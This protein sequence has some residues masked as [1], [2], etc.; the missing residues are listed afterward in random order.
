MATA[1]EVGSDFNTHLFTTNAV[2]SLHDRNAIQSTILSI[3]K[4]ISQAKLDISQLRKGLEDRIADHADLI[5]HRASLASVISLLRQ[6]PLEI[7]GQIFAY[8]TLDDPRFPVSASHVCQLW[9]RASL[10]S[11]DIW[12]TICIG[13][14]CRKEYMELFIQ[15]SKSRPVSLKYSGNLPIQSL[16]DISTVLSDVG[17]NCRWKEIHVHPR[18]NSLPNIL[19]KSWDTLES[20]ILTTS[21]DS[22]VRVLDLTSATQLTHISVVHDKMSRFAYYK[23]RFPFSTLTHLI[24]DITTT[25]PNEIIS[26]MRAC[27]NLEEFVLTLRGPFIYYEDPPSQDSPSQ[28]P[29][30]LPN[31]RKLHLHTVVL[32]LLLKFLQTPVVEDLLVDPEGDQNNFNGEDE[33]LRTFINESKS[34]L[35]KLS[36]SMISDLE[37]MEIIEVM[38]GLSEF[39]VFG[40]DDFEAEFLEE[41][42]VGGEKGGDIVS[43][44]S[45]QMDDDDE[46]IDENASEI[47]LP[48]LEVLHVVCKPYS[49][50]QR[51]FLD[52]VR[53]RWWSE[54]ESSSY[55]GT[56]T[57]LKAVSLQSIHTSQ[58]LAFGTEVDEIRRRGFDVRM[59]DEGQEPE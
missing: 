44:M 10:A 59:L 40:S 5:Q 38:K 58:R 11:S 37:F 30:H 19:S 34:T 35:R 42:I 1:Y 43:E 4:D 26:I 20:L 31:L 49:H 50:V 47:R 36:I 24:L 16:P 53:S 2:P 46:D 17:W 52:V 54:D 48:N 22:M 25:P 32:F 33:T 8:T 18:W 57:R 27:R 21:G 15:R 39:R 29:V 14:R 12:T 3:D 56:V 55:D 9:R 6:L 13:N 7:F 41:L 28:T 23:F 51:A 45:G